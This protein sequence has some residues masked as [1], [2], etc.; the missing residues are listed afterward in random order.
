MAGTRDTGAWLAIAAVVAVSWWFW[1]T[2]W[3]WPLKILVVLFHE[4]GHAI[5]T[6]L[7]GGRVLEIH[8][9]WNQSGHALSEGGWPFVTLNAGYL[10][11]LAFGVALLML[12]KRPK[13]A[14]ATTAALGVGLV[15]I[16]LG[17]VRPLI[18]FGTAFTAATGFALLA[19]ARWLPATG[20]AWLVRGIGAFSVLYM[21]FDV[22]DDVFRVPRGTLTDATMLAERTG[23]PAAVWGVG[24][25]LVAAATLWSLRRRLA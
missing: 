18:S 20:T 6:W 25:L 10:G 3:L 21:L 19:A 16:A 5:A 13:A 4:L 17:W 9:A 12:A 22:R 11:S 1:D 2:A 24:W 8:V 23:V 7:T 15:V 14:A